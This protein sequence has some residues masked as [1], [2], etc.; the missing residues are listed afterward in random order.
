M[1]VCVCVC[2]CVCYSKGHLGGLGVVE[3][4]LTNLWRK[5]PTL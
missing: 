5:V 1:C 3:F 2:V 4:V